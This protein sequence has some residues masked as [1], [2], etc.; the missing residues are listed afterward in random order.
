MRTRRGALAALFACLGSTLVH[1]TVAVALLLRFG[2]A[3]GGSGE[4]GKRGAG[5]DTIDVTLAGAT[6]QTAASAAPAPSAPTPKAPEP[7]KQPPKE[8]PTPRA[9][10]EHATRE[11]VVDPTPPPPPAP[12]TA[13]AQSP[14]N[15][16]A[17]ATESGKLAGPVRIG[18][19]NLGLGGDSVAGQRA[20]LPRAATCSDPVA[21]HWE[22]LKFSPAQGDWVHFSLT[23]RR[24]GD[25]LEGTILSHTWAGTAFDRTPPECTFGG[26]DLTVVMHA[27]GRAAAAGRITFGASSY[28]VVGVRCASLNNSYAPDNFSGAID[29][30]RQE[31]QS[32]NNDGA[33]DVNAPYVFRRTGCLDASK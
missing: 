18:A 7:K 6:A 32:V 3:A 31:F 24:A 25:A 11:P 20:L 21:G 15:G 29:P 26:F 14:S 8:P 33:N 4:G 23:V 2:A 22:A 13:T 10:D 5:G 28:S 17:A 19:P 1:G 30:A 12:A 27:T 16:N 9:A